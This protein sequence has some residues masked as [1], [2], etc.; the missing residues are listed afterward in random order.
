MATKTLFPLSRHWLDASVLIDAKNGPY[1]FGIAVGFWTWLAGKVE[2]GVIVSPKMC[3]DEIVRNEEAKD[4]LA[5]WV[6]ARRQ[7]GLCIKPDREVQHLVGQIG[8]Y[9]FSPRYETQESLDFSRGGDIWLIAHAMA[10]NG[11]VVTQESHR[12]PDAKKVRIPD[13]CYRFGVSCI[14]LNEL[15]RKLK[16]RF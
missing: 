7:R 15:I 12:R 16:A 1:P 10:D 14:N 5:R 13:V 2:A 6:K 8:E 4:E 3:Y 9:V 11:T